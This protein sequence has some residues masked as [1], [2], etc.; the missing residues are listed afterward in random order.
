MQIKYY[1]IFVIVSSLLAVHTG[2]QEKL[3]ILPQFP[4]RGDSITIR[5]NAAAPGA[6]LP[7]TVKEVEL[8][9]TNTNFY[10]L[11]FT[12]A[13]RKEGKF[14]ETSFRLPPYATF[15]TFYLRSGDKKEQPAP[16][17]QF[18]IT[19]YNQ[20]RRVENSYLYEGYSLSAQKGRVPGLAAMQAALYGEELKH[21]P[22]NYEAKLRLLQYKMSAAATE[23][24][25]EKYRQAAEAIIAAKFYEN[26]G[27][28]G[29][30]NRVTMGYLIIGENSRLDSIR[31]VVK[32]KYPHTEAGY[33][34]LLD[35]IAKG[36]DTVQMIVQFE[37]LLKTANTGQ[38]KYLRGIHQELMKLYAGQGREDKALYYLRKTGPDE[39]PY[40][41]QTLKAQAAVLLQAGIGLDTA[42]QLLKQALALADQFPAGLIRYFP[43]TGY[44]PAYVSPEKRRLATQKAKGNLL[45]LLALLELKKGHAAPALQYVKEA[46]EASADVETLANAATVYA[47]T[48]RYQHAFEAY[49]N[50][51]LQ[52]PEDTVSLVKMKDSYSHWKSSLAGWESE[53]EALHRHWAAETTAQLKKEM[54]ELKAPAFIQQL[55]DLQGRPLSA[56]RLKNKI[57]ILDFWATWCVPCMQEMPYVQKAYEKYA[58]AEDVAFMVINSGAKNTLQDAQ[59]WWGN[60]KFTFPVYYNTDAQIGDKLGF[61]VIPAV[62]I[63]D[64][65]GDIRFKTIGFE[66]P[67]IQRKM[68]AAIELLRTGYSKSNSGTQR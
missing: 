59:Q 14:W 3:Q 62:Y 66:G 37:K 23:A 45:S 65:K 38:Q 50:L 33:E 48:R 12:M 20:G 35:E 36:T 57:L 4:Q 40:R 63:I 22:N 32:E 46:L 16:D 34:L 58:S 64:Q 29:L 24:E 44:L 30:L 19:V 39:S 54:V 7:D 60:K 6:T 10:E 41:P 13:L 11:P 51:L 56:E 53:V 55:V 68:E 42:S 9:F 28:M 2:A 31:R 18:A 25:K 67:S 52:A 47:Q 26:P 1:S 15:A 49:K 43:E 17:R 61:S 27:N 5:Y 8:V 21:Y